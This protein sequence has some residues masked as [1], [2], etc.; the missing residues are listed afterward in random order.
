MLGSLYTSISGLKGHL[1]ALNVSGNNISNVNSIGFKGGRTTFS[2]TLVQTLRGATSPTDGQGGTSPMQLGLGMGVGSIDNILSQGVLQNTGVPTDLGINGEGFFILSD[3][4]REYYSR[5]G[6]FG[7]DAEGNM[8]NP[9]NG[10][11]LQGRMADE[12][13]NINASEP[14]GNL[15]LPF[16]TKVP[17]RATSTVYMGCNLNAAATDSV[18]ELIS[19]G[20]TGITSASGY[21]SNG[22]GG[23]H[24]IT[25]V[26]AN[27]T[28]SSAAGANLLAPAALDGTETL[29]A[30]GVTDFSDF[31][32][33]V[34]GGPDI[35]ITGLSGSSTVQDVIIAINDLVSGVGAKIEGGEVVLTRDYAGDGAAY[36]ITS[37]LG[38]AG[39]ISRQI[40]GAAVGSAFTVNNGTAST[41]VATDVFT[42]TGKAAIAP[43]TLELLTDSNSGLVMGIKDVGNGGITIAA[44][45]GLAAGTAVVDTEE[46]EHYTSVLVY[47]SI[48]SSHNL[49]VRFTRSA[50]ENEWYWDTSLGGSEIVKGGQ[51]G[52]VRF[53]TD[54]SL[55]YFSYD[56]GSTS[57]VFDPG[58][59]ADE[60]HVAL[61]AGIAGT[62]DG[63]TQFASPFST[64]ARSQDGCGMGDLT[65]ISI[66]S[67]GAI[68]GLF[69][70]GV[71]KTIAQ[72]M[73]AKFNNPAGLEK[74]GG[75]LYTRSNNSGLAIKGEPGQI[76]EASISAG[77]LEMSN[78]DLAEEFVSM[79][80]AQRGFQANARV[81]S[82][83][84]EMLSEVVN[85]R[86]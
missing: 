18:S 23:Q 70:N 54:G 61:D 67:T 65:S 29:T 60:V 79:I 82:A 4:N 26:G 59:G 25:I 63:V 13:G 39:N 35:A 22:A 8:I 16:G 48:G 1:I 66:G 72:V 85:I 36:N 14:V 5:V 53:N 69:S 49:S 83:S 50:V 80:V 45:T 2:E 37:S 30:L 56:G 84:D 15:L 43:E 81:L 77:T 62:F 7:Y 78:V 38:V 58:N 51:S 21:A 42:P 3:G 52:S 47:D 73:L 86:R 17:A 27:A 40:L 44:Q 11:I 31:T 33:S 24:V 19:A 12:Q 46:T 76:V 32:M 75:G 28:A 55:A 6:S 10:L 57:M 9:T 68:T 20:T 41:L 71:S 74:V 34:D 64:T